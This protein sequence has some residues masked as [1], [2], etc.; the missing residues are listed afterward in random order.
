MGSLGNPLAVTTRQFSFDP[1]GTA[2]IQGHAHTG[3][4]LNCRVTNPQGD[5]LTVY[6]HDIYTPSSRCSLPSVSE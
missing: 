1:L 4:M 5:W 6:L 3:R 2:S